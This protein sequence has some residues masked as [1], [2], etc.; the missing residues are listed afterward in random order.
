MPTLDFHPNIEMDICTIKNIQILALHYTPS[1]Y[2]LHLQTPL[3]LDSLSSLSWPG[4]TIHPIYDRL[5]IF[6]YM[7][8]YKYI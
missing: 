7:C 4:L 1:M 6:H 2:D 5:S 8:V 3:F